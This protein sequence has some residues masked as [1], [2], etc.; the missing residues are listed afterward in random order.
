MGNKLLLIYLLAI[1][2]PFTFTSCE[3]AEDA[4]DVN[5]DRIYTRYEL[6]YNENTDITTARANFRFGGSTGTLLELTN[7]GTVSFNN[8]ELT[9]WVEPITNIT[10]Y[11]KDYA[12]YVNT[13]TFSYTDIDGNTFENTVSGDVVNFPTITQVD[14]TQAFTFTWVGNALA[15]DEEIWLWINGVNEG[16]AQLFTQ[17]ADGA[18]DMILGQNQLEQVALGTS[19]WVM[20]R[21][22]RSDVLDAPGAGGILRIGYKPTNIQV[23]IVE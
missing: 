17:N 10:W 15:Q 7:G 8:D 4:N 9:E 22:W 13:G 11:K 14:R 2:L 12:G 5:Q 23:E 16:D 21:V 19:D 1:A 3:D 6:N 18:S 20:E